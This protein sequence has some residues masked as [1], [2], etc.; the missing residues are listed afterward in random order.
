[1]TP[2]FL[3]PWLFPFSWVL[4]LISS[5][6]PRSLNFIP[7]APCDLVCEVYRPGREVFCLVDPDDVAPARLI[8]AV[9]KLPH[10]LVVAVG[11]VPAARNERY[12]MVLEDLEGLATYGLPIKGRAHSL[13]IELLVFLSAW[14]KEFVVAHVLLLLRDCERGRE[15]RAGRGVR[16]WGLLLRYRGHLRC[17]ALVCGHSSRCL[18]F[19]SLLRSHSLASLAVRN[20]QPKSRVASLKRSNYDVMEPSRSV[21]CYKFLNVVTQQA[22]RVSYSLS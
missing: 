9:A 11:P 5:R 8:P 12:A 18:G 10:G 14:N 16:H 17:G 7:F 15:H 2:S 22:L 13:V 20:P 3:F 6:V 19:F 4:P 21:V 1:M